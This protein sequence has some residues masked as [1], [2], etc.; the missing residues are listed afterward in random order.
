M[1]HV[2]RYASFV[3]TAAAG[4]AWSLAASLAGAAPAA[5]RPATNPAT[6][7]ATRPA[8]T[9]PAT[10]V[11]E[12]VRQLA[13]ADWRGREAAVAQVVRAGDEAVPLLEAL[14]RTTESLDARSAAQDALAQIA[15]NRVAGPSFVTLHLD[16]ADP[17]EAFARLARQAGAD[18]QP[19]PDNLWT[20]E[21]WPRV[22]LHA[23]REPFWSVLRQLAGQA[24]VELREINGTLRV[25]Q[26]SGQTAGRAVVQGAFLVVAS[27]ITRTQTIDLT[28]D[29][30]ATDEHFAIQLSAF[31]EPKLTVLRAAA[32]LTLDE[33]VDD[34]GNDLVP[35]PDPANAAGGAD[36]GFY[37]GDGSWSLQAQLRYP[38]DPGTR[39]ARL[40]ATAAFTLQSKSQR[41]ELGNLSAVKDREQTVAGTRVVFR[42]FK[43]TDADTYTLRVVVAQQPDA[44]EAW[45]QLHNSLQTRLKVLDAAGQPLDP[46]GYG[47]TG[48][49]NEVE[50]ILTFGPSQR[51]E[52]GRKSG[53][54]VRVVWEV[55]TETR[56]VIV[57][58]EFTDL[59]LPGR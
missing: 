52:D 24:G 9:R 25:M 14:V 26:G 42:D 38:K 5:T 44:G 20:Q 40:R 13:A 55:P 56:D 29:R 50:M 18:L 33:A 12:L 57:P 10:P 41:V 6:S 54:P 8:A 37:G 4:G 19:Y 23:E 15:S 43:K 48:R 21:H 30:P 53:D 17:R 27:Q 1:R 36:G 35:P 47:S 16:D 39:I 22:T 49:N 2:Q 58:F 45:E 28:A 3:V 31:A 46:R 11:A 51:P 32:G 59:P 34:R 7:P